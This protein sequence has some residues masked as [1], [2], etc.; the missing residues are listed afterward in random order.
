MTTLQAPLSGE[1]P[2][3]TAAIDEPRVARETGTAARVAGT[4]TPIL[5][6]LGY[7]LVRVKLMA[8]PPATLQIMAERPDGSM[9]IEGCELVSKVL[10]PLLDLND[11]VSGAYRLEVSSPGID[12]PLVRRSDYARA[13]GHEARIELAVPMDGRKRFKGLLRGVE[14]GNLTLELMDAKPG[15]DSSV[16]LPLADIGEAKLVLTDALIRASLRGER[17]VGEGEAGTS[18]A[19]G[20]YVHKPKRAV[21][22][23][24]R[25]SIPRKKTS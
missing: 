5:A 17:D 21:P 25:Q 3:D 20:R 6:E 4:A 15:A 16:V 10:S 1:G 24:P 8:G 19:P 12:R 13:L 14:D 7:R 23:G 18:P 9:T 22:A 2:P 11:P